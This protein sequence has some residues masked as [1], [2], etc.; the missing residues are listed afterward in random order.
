MKKTVLIIMVFVINLC[1]AGVTKIYLDYAN[2]L[3]YYGFNLDGFDKIH[4]PFEP[5]IKI[6]NGKK[7]KETKTLLKSINITL[8][9]VFNNQA[10][11]LIKEYVGDQLIKSYKKWVAINDN[12]GDCKVAKI[13]LSKVVLKCKNQT[14][15]KTLNKKIPGIKE[16]K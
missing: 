8:L 9:T 5:V 12:I 7:I 4:A 6:V 13:K 16:T 1:A 15:V 11:V 10:Y 2:K 3:V 14:L